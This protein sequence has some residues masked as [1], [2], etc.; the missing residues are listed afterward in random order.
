M[1]RKSAFDKGASELRQEGAMSISG[2]DIPG[3]RCKDPEARLH[4]L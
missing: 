2:E 4:Y 3:S 1:V